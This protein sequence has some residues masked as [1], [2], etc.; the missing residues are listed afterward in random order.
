M[1]QLINQTNNMG[2][3]IAAGNTKPVFPYDYYYGVKIPLAV[4]DPTLERVGRPELHVSLP[5]QSRMRRCIL[6][7]NGDVNYYLHPTDSTKKDSGAAAKLDGTDGMYMV[8]LPEHY[9]KFEFDG[10][11]YFPLISEYPL[12]GFHK[13][14]KCYRSAVQAT[15]D[16]TV[17]ATPKL[18]AVCNTTA[19]FRGGN[20][21]ATL[22]GTCKSLLGMP[23]TATSLTNF[24]AYARNRGN[25]GLNGAG[26]NCDLFEAQRTTFWLFTIEYATLNSQTEFNPQPDANGYKQGGLGAGA[27]S[28]NSTKWYNYNGYYP[29]IPCGITNSLGNATGVVEFTMPDEYDPGVVTKIKATSYRGIEHPFG[30]IWSFTDGCLCLIQTNE[31]GGRSIFY[32]C[33]DPAHFGSTT[34]SLEFYQE[35]GD[36]PRANGYIKSMM[37]GEYGENM[38]AEV[39]SGANSNTYFCDYFYTNI[40]TSDT[41]RSVLFGGRAYNGA[42]AGLAYSDTTYAPTNT[43]ASIGSRLCFIPAA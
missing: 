23:A 37:I 33:D 10:N 19:P 26:W 30:H 16:R 11:N 17:V 32:T 13:V 34:A 4:A 1:G 6:K 7:D 2:L 42:Y 5:I 27:T 40:P 39:G 18:A 25:A 35:R 20:N 15:I 36:L 22:D 41:L 38:P 9:A 43:N 8:E 28:I 21:N 3:I 14:R 24:R 29:F 12:P 31:T